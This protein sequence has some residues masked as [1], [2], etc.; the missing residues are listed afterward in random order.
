MGVEVWL[1][2]DVCSMMHNCQSPGNLGVLA[3]RRRTAEKPN[4]RRVSGRRGRIA[5][6]TGSTAW[7]NLPD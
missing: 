6:V 1:D 2:A 5:A 4:A 7:N 3:S